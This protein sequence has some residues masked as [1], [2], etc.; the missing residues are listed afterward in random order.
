MFFIKIAIV[1]VLGVITYQD[2]K[3]REVYGF[4]FPIL[5]GLLG[6]L[7]YQ[8]VLDIH[9]YN[10]LIMN[11]VI[12]FFTIGLMYLYA[13]LRIKKPFFSE[14]F[15]IGDLLFFLALAIGF[16]TVTFTIILVFS[17]LFA[18]IVWEVLKKNSKYTTIPL[19][20]Y[21]AIFTGMILIASC[22]INDVTLYLI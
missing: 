21:M 10:A 22:M 13:V 2:L 3:D 14:V 20:G 12:L 1:C 15:G 7:H 17:L 9:F 11:G 19:A 6:A 5:M 8:S 18:L 4:V 16:P